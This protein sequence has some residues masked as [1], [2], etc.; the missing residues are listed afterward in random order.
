[1]HDVAIAFPLLIVMRAA[2]AAV[3]L[4][5][6]LWCKV[7]GRAQLEAQVVAKVPRF[8]PRFGQS[9]LKALGVVEVVLAGWVISGIYPGA[10][11]I[12]EVALLVVLN[13]N[14]LLWSRDIIPDPAGMIVK[15][16]AFLVLAWACG[17]I[18]GR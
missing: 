1:M 6:G 5:E 17:A 15:N 12:V 7:L 16:I 4:Y 3:W 18:P 11:A 14:G 13:V 8:G 10:C 9:F 2:V